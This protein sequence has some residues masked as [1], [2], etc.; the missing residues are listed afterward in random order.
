MFTASILVVLMALLKFEG[1][2]SVTVGYTVRMNTSTAE[3]EK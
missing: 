2:S 3:N 1:F